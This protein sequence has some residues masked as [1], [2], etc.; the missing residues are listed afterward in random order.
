MSGLKI[1]S[2]ILPILLITSVQRHRS[3]PPA[4]DLGNWREN[5]EI[6][7]NNYR[8]PSMV[9]TRRSEWFVNK[10]MDSRIRPSQ[11]VC[12]LIFY[13]L[14]NTTFGSSEANAVSNKY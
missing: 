14:H 7:G 9:R 2:L 6:L 13:T 12:Q 1:F 4:H 8:V 3:S 5:F 11:T 10:R